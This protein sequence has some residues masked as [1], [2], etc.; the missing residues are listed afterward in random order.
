MIDQDIQAETVI[1]KAQ[2]YGHNYLKGSIIS[3][4]EVNPVQLNEIKVE[5]QLQQL[6]EVDEM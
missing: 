1:Q 6:N 5:V 4:S 3:K 2:D